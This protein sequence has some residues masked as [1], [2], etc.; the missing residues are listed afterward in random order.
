MKV[1]VIGLGKLGACV[2]AVLAESG[3]LVVGVDVNG[4]AV[5]LLDRRQS[6][7]DETG[8]DR[9][10]KDIDPHLLHATTSYDD[11][12]AMT[13]LALI[14]VPTPTDP[15]TGMFDPRYVVDVMHELGGALRS[16]QRPYT[17]VVSSTVMPGAM[18]EEIIPELE[19]AYGDLVGEDLHV[20]YN[21]LFIALGSV[22]N[23]LRHPD[24]VLIGAHDKRAAGTVA[25][26]S[27][28][29]QRG[30]P[31]HVMSLV[32]AELTKLSVNVYLSMKIAAA[33]TVAAF[34]RRLG[35]DPR[36]VLRAVGADS[37]IGVKYLQPGG[38][39][40]GPCLARDLR[41]I[42]ALADQ[43]RVPAALAAATI[44]AGD[45][46]VADIVSRAVVAVPKQG[47]VAVL[48]LSYKPGTAVT[49]DSL[50][51]RLL[52]PLRRADLDLSVHDP[53]A[54]IDLPGIWQTDSAQAAV[55][56]ASAVIIACPHP[57]YATLE[58]GSRTVIDP[59]Y[60]VRRPA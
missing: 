25:E 31:A 57:E 51:V 13:D 45:E 37:R 50:A 7:V 49:D 24:F 38:P 12:V 34:S 3:H 26:L 59:W 30:A 43:V 10:L 27:S 47:T 20:A 54:R 18:T 56:S 46:V 14:V 6:P 16:H 29:Y 60:H 1:A 39:A 23:D 15:N 53:A 4:R 2:A 11:A 42:D 8:L 9:L 36:V 21:P 52:A 22:I 35:A 58:F 41:A 55:D 33:N 5:E 19:A 28:T 44:E 32:E 17:V 40:G 48:G